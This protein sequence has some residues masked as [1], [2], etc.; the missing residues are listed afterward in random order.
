MSL[1]YLEQ[2]GFLKPVCKR[3]MCWEI[4]YSREFKS[5]WILICAH[6]NHTSWLSIPGSIYLNLRPYVFHDKLWWL[7]L[8]LK[9]YENID[10]WFPRK[11]LEPRHSSFFRLPVNS[12]KDAFFVL[13]FHKAISNTQ[14]ITCKE[15]SERQFGNVFQNLS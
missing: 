12:T 13:A 3:D 4:K 5:S 14:K 1:W 7:V 15:N 9:R 11:C 10:S 8:H 6:A 2:K